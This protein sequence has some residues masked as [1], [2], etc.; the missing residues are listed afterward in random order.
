MKSVL[1]P[2]CLIIFGI[3]GDLAQRK[4]LPALCDLAQHGYLPDS[5]RLVGISRKELDTDTL[6]AQLGARHPRL[7]SI[8]WDW[9]KDRT[10][11]TQMDLLNHDDYI[12]LGHQ[13]EAI[14]NTASSCLQRL[15][16]LAIPAQ[17]YAPIIEH[18][19]DASLQQGCSHGHK[20]RL[21]IEKPFGYDLESA[22]ELI[23]LI[24][25]IFA[26]EQTFRIDHYLA[27]ET[28]QNILTFRFKNALFRKAW[29]NSHISSVIIR[30]HEE[31]GIE[32]RGN[33]YEQTGALRDLIQ[34]HLLQML[35]L[36]TMH[37]PASDGTADIH[38]CK[39]AA[40]HAI[41][42]V[43]PDNVASHTIRGQYEGYADEI[44]NQSSATETYAAIKLF[45]ADPA[46][47][48]I[49]LIL[50]TGKA[51]PAKTIAIAVQ[52]DD[53]STQSHTNTLTFTVQPSEG[54]TM[55]FNAKQPG[56]TNQTEEVEMHFDYKSG[57]SIPKQG[58][59]AYVR[60]I[61]DAMRGDRLL[62]ATSEEVLAAWTIIQPVLDEWQKDAIDMVQYA[63]GSL[64]KTNPAFWN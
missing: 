19:G 57:F 7:N 30:A 63:H 62:F 50:E 64:P 31:I 29:D 46:W 13:L 9:L 60:V 48:G 34:S 6:F 55:R 21:L 2:T 36:I 61:A 38:Q 28:V 56:L 10:T 24:R 37:E 25:S 17:T 43:R 8:H 59:E 18:L 52:F 41:H 22:K 14:E 49:P 42:P 27:K 32:N 51:L 44:G 35:A 39:T 23:V 58:L 3:S 1:P 15:F 47:H 53:N 20:S 33:F 16:Y 4:L 45:S 26:E 12:E 54:I 5:F 11:L 40:L